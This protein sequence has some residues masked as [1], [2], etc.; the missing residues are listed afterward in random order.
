MLQSHLAMVCFWIQRKA[1]PYR[2]V[3]IHNGVIWFV[4]LFLLMFMSLRLDC[5]WDAVVQEAAM[6]QGRMC[7][8]VWIT[9]SWLTRSILTSTLQD[10]KKKSSFLKDC[11][12]NDMYNWPL[13]PTD[14][15]LALSGV[16]Y[17]GMK[18]FQMNVFAVVTLVVEYC[19]TALVKKSNKTLHFFTKLSCAFRV[20]T[21]R[22][23]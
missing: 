6:A 2:C 9:V 13:N 20:Y 8:C 16:S 14:E 4:C 1:N 22:W 21:A 7:V 5:E 3:V 19:C 17:I 11:S 18:A 10:Q 12:S 23:L 15:L